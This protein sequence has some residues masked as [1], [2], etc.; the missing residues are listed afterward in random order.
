MTSIDD[1]RMVEPRRGLSLGTGATWLRLIDRR[2]LRLGVDERSTIAFTALLGVVISATSVVQALV[3]ARALSRVIDGA[4]LGSV[5][6]LFVAVIGVIALRCVATWRYHTRSAATAGRIAGKLRS[7]LY[8][9]VAALG[10]GWTSARRSGSL[11]TTLVDG[12][13][14]VEA[15]FRLFVAQV[16]ASLITAVG[17][18]AAL[19]VIDPVVGGVV[20][21]LVFIAAIG[22]A[23]SWRLLGT[24]LRHWWTVAPAMSA[25]YVDAMQGISTLK[26][27]GASRTRGKAL[28]ARAGEVL[29]ANISL[30]NVEYAAL[31]P[32]SLAQVAAGV[33]A[34]WLGVVRLGDGAL[35][36]AELL[37]VLMLVGEAL[38]PVNETKRALH[39]AMQGMGAAEGVLDI[40]EATPSV[41]EPNLSAA[42]RPT[43][44]SHDIRFEDVS[45]RYRPS[46]EFALSGLT[47]D[48]QPGET[49]A[50]I[51]RSGAGKTTV[52]SMLMRFFDPT[53]GA[54][55]VGGID[56]RRMPLAELRGAIAL[57]P[58][59][60]YLF[61]GT[62]ADNLRIAR[63]SATDSELRAAAR[64]AAADEF[65]DALA[66]GYDT[67]VGERGLLLSG[68]QRQRIAIARAFL[69]DAPILVL[70]EATASVDV[71]SERKIQSALDRLAAGRTVLVIAHRLSTIRHADRI[72]VIES[73]RAVEAG[74]HA[75]LAAL[76]G[77]YGDL[78]R[79]D[80]WNSAASMRGDSS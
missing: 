80:G 18:V 5:T 10:P 9:A 51:G 13:E 47:F 58:Q 35:S 34:I 2:V 3:V 64:E 71:A 49:V 39:S 19:I 74:D 22:P 38:R 54:I 61:A 65:I 26:M 56:I 8:R 68:G 41:N 52:A 63:P 24:R 33:A 46:G 37:V 25:E 23:L 60:T 17:V 69:A 36:T 30:N 48:V 50:L 45:F 55:R 1:T 21:S 16:A 66:D 62:I 73:G 78:L 7:D 70:D 44:T 79:A 4:S 32:F 67:E 75:T 76:D 12:V 59:D 6:P 43:M 28:E 53:T 77:R 57:V 15:Y 11:Q 20:G 27:F 29:A 14:Q 40:L 42:T 72:V 31:Q